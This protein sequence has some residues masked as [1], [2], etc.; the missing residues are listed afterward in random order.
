MAASPSRP[1]KTALA[2]PFIQTS[3]G[4][5]APPRRAE[6]WE[7]ATGVHVSFEKFI[8]H[9]VEVDWPAVADGAT[10]YGEWESPPSGTSAVTA[11]HMTTGITNKYSLSRMTVVPQTFA[12]FTAIFGHSWL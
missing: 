2:V 7:M 1:G 5:V 9:I 10:I 8:G 12:E 11:R 6:L 4:K 3:H